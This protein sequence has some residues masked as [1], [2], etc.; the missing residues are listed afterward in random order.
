MTF[1][2]QLIVRG[3]A[4]SLICIATF[5]EALPVV[6][7]NAND[8]GAGSL[9][10]A[11]QDVNRLL[12]DEIQFRAAFD[13]NLA[14]ALD[15]FAVGVKISG[16]PN[17]K[18]SLNNTLENTIFN[19]ASNRTL[20][21]SGND[22][23]G[24]SNWYGGISGSAGGILRLEQQTSSTYSGVI[25]G[26][27]SL[28]FQGVGHNIILGNASTYTG[29]T[30][31]ASGT[32]NVGFA[33][34][35]PTGTTVNISAG[36]ILGIGDGF[37]Q[38]LAG[39]TGNGFVT[40]G[41]A[42]TLKI[43]SIADSTF[44]GTMTG[45]GGNFVKQG[46]GTFTLSNSNTYTG[47]T[48]ILA[49]TLQAN[50]LN[51]LPQATAV[52]ISNNGTL[53]ITAANAQT[54]QS[55]S[56]N[57]GI[58]VDNAATLTINTIAD[59]NFAGNI[60]TI[61]TGVFVKAGTNTLTLSGSNTG[62][63]ELADAAGGVKIPTGGSWDGSVTIGAATLEMNGGTVTQAITGNV[64]STS[65]LNITGAFT[66]MAAITN[67]GSINV[68]QGGTLVLTN[69][70]VGAGGNV[71]NAGTITHTANATR[72]IAGNL[73]QEATGTLNIG[74]TNAAQY[75]QF[76]VNGN[77][78]LNGGVMN[79]QL[80]STAQTTNGT[81]F[82]IITSTG[83]IAGGSVL[84]SVP[85]TSLFFRFTP[86]VTGNTLQLVANR[87]SCMFVNSIPPLN[88]IAQ[89]VDNVVGNDKF[90]SLVN[91][92]DQQTSQ[93]AF[94]K[95]LEQLAPTG[96]NGIHTVMAQGSGGVEHVLLRLDTLRAMGTGGA[97]ARTGYIRTGYAAGDVMEDRGSYG[98]IVFGN[99]TKQSM[100]EGLSGYKAVT[101]GVGF[102]G[103]APILEDFRVGLGASYANSVVR[104]SNNTGSHVKIGSTQGM[105]Y[106][107]ATYGRVFLDAVLSAG[108]NNYHGKRNVTFMGP[109]ATSRY[110]G[111][112]YGAKVKTGFAI[113]CYRID[114]SP[115]AA[116]Q[117]MYLHVGQYTEQGAGT[118]LNQ[119]LNAMQTS[120]VRVNLGGRI[121]E[122]SQEGTFF[123]EF[124]AFYI[125]DV[126]NPQVIIT[127]QFVEGGGSFNSTSVVPPK[128][129]VNL[130]AS[131]TALLSDNFTLS[132]G[133]D[134]EKKKSFESHSASLK[135][136][137]L[138]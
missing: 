27:V 35:L 44:G 127:S 85:K 36:G 13:I 11:V 89:G 92:L 110:N 32:V 123:P 133:Y 58:T 43:D 80:L 138:F 53:E 77:T 74:I 24:S 9:R 68:Q 82:D 61:G 71:D 81:V 73:T 129:G 91:M 83:G 72:T 132:G 10:Q 128:H 125:T 4:L 96:L 78:V 50:A 14:S 98:P 136:K 12:Y 29:T 18:I 5:A 126:K 106:G 19:N 117:Y 97:L 49:G 40:I 7:Q 108:I 70:I 2:K 112:Q 109:T 113:P 30:S 22:I 3:T 102:L 17:L 65:I 118:T 99:S 90:S 63:L 52:T 88:G 60:T 67:V 86:V 20:Y 16:V 55:I 8:T 33:N 25:S 15:P 87:S 41:N 45:V 75:S 21:L 39:L 69:D 137:F 51:A 95:T 124:H 105:A 103:D 135:F 131:V 59:G 56:G 48:A 116:V 134:L 76:Q 23:A 57:G 64:L 6:V 37:T 107:S 54:L 66:S 26:S 100:R 62:N 119:H 47:T 115:I 111:F 93:Q 38:T 31:I 42:S 34:A 1:F 46:T 101:A 114:I 130:G 84:P 121:A 120:T 94:E 28:I 79:V 122:N 104:Q